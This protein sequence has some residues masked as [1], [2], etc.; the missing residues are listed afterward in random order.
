MKSGPN[1]VPTS[2]KHFPLVGVDI[3][4]MGFTN[5]FPKGINFHSVELEEFSGDD[6]QH[7][8]DMC[9]CTLQ[10]LTAVPRGSGSH[11]FLSLSSGTIEPSFNFLQQGTVIKW[12]LN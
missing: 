4:A 7:L 3:A 2:K 6:A 8:L 11:R 10:S 1:Q 5:E 9:A 12:S